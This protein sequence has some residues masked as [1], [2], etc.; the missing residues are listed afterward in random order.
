MAVRSKKQ[1]NGSW[2]DNNRDRNGPDGRG[3]ACSVAERLVPFG[4][5]AAMI[6]PAGGTAW[7][8]YDLCEARCFQL[9]WMP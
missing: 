7:I 1:L 4:N 2:K 5:A 9:N 8:C 3:T 6:F